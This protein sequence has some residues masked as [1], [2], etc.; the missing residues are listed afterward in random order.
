[1]KTYCSR[2][3]KLLR[4]VFSTL[5]S[6]FKYTFSWFSF[7]H[8]H[9][10]KLPLAKIVLCFLF[11]DYYV[12]CG[13]LA[14][15][16]VWIDCFEELREGEFRNSNLVFFYKKWLNPIIYLLTY[17][18]IT[19]QIYSTDHISQLRCL[20]ISKFYSTA[21]SVVASFLISLILVDNSVNLNY[22]N[23]PFAAYI[24]STTFFRYNKTRVRITTE[25]SWNHTNLN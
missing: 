11:T 6:F 12:E 21:L 22:W 9:Q 7:T 8:W 24:E 5:F 23:F 18:F 13:I 4:H 15:E 14:L 2:K 16:R 19:V 1:M 20:L 3:P 10:F 25:L 17:T